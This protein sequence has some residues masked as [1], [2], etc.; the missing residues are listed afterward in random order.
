MFQHSVNIDL[1][2][3]FLFTWSFYWHN[4]CGTFSI[5][6]QLDILDW[7]IWRGSDSRHDTNLTLWETTIALSA[8]SGSC[9]P[10]LFVFLRV[11]CEPPDVPRPHRCPQL[12]PSQPETHPGGKC[13]CQWSLVMIF[14]TSDVTY[15]AVE[16]FYE[17][18]CGC[19]N[20]TWLSPSVASLPQGLASLRSNS[21]YFNV[22][23]IFPQHIHV[24]T[25]STS[26]Q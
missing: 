8:V 14:G 13:Q 12:R 20:L 18:S 5:P 19:W 26:K 9:S 23:K 17:C 7:W 10:L 24:K 11:S 15:E 21:E 25:F 16:I 4:Y 1:C 22:N 3:I 2:I 6:W